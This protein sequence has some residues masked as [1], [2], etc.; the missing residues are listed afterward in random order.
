M[1]K[2]LVVVRQKL[3]SITRRS[4]FFALFCCLLLPLFFLACYGASRGGQ[5][6]FLMASA[7]GCFSAAGAWFFL[8]LWEKKMQHSVE[9]LVQAKIEKLKELPA[10]IAT[11]KEQEIQHLKAEVAQLNQ[12]MD[13]K[14]EAM[15]VA[16]LEFED[17][18]KEYR[19]LDEESTRQKDELT[20]DLDQK[21]ALLNEYQKTIS[22]QRAILEKRQRHIFDLER[23]VR[24]LI[25][26]IRGLLQLETKG[27]LN[28]SDQAMLD[29]FLSA[30]PSLTPYDLSVQLHKSIE[31][32]E[33]LTG[34][35][36]LGYLGG[37]SPRFLDLSL[38]SY[39]VD[40]RRLFDTFRD[41][42]AGIIFVYCLQERK[43][44]FVNNQTKNCLGIGPEKFIKEFHHLVVKGYV[45][46]EESLA[47]TKSAKETF[48]KL[49]V[50]HKEGQIRTFECHMRKIS[51]GPFTH[52]ILGILAPSS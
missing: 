9:Q 22:E 31:K 19:N 2:T 5:G 20:Q 26:E 27:E 43:F 41:D 13:T 42:T 36:H 35:G 39:T 15:R 51:K 33:A 34:V 17:L 29:V 1:E 14:L 21:K 49:A 28:V 4:I 12:E 37:K 48:L 11:Q 50:L 45:E 24:E 10:E 3:T 47:K 25:Q 16:Y 30:A 23:K 18:R 6:I 38:E 32:V 46:W 52:C 40:K 7:C 44:I 8:R